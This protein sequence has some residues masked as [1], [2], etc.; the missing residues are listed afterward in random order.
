MKRFTVADLVRAA[1]MASN[2]PWKDQSDEF[3][4]LL[5]QE[6]LSLSKNALYGE[7]EP[8]HENRLMKAAEMFGFVLAIGVEMARAA[9]SQSVSINTFGNWDGRIPE[10]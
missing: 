1:E 5:A 8:R 2:D 9:A 3:L 4:D 10:A 6:C 7:I